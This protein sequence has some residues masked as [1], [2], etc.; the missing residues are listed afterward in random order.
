LERTTKLVVVTWACLAVAAESWLLRGAWAGIVPA[1]IAAFGAA[2]VAT[3]FNR[4]AVGAVLAFTYIFPALI[5]LIR[6]QYHASYGVVWTAALVGAMAPDG[7]RTP[8]H[9]PARWRPALVCSA[10]I[11]IG[12][13]LVA[14]WRE[15][16]FYPGLIFREHAAGPLFM[17]QWILQV[18]LV[19]VVGI[20]WFD[21]L[22]GAASAGPLDMHAT[23]LMPLA[24]SAALMASVAVYQLFVD[25]RW[26]NN[27]VYGEIA[28]ASGTVFDANVC[29]TIAGLW[30]GGVLLWVDGCHRWKPWLMAGGVTL[31]WLAVWATGSRTGFASAVITSGFAVAAFFV[32]RPRAPSRRVIPA[33]LTVTTLGV[34]LL[35]VLTF[36][37]LAAIGPLRRFWTTLPT[38]SGGSV[39][40]F[41]VEN[42]WTR[43]GYGS[44]AVE[45][46]RRFPWFGVGLGSFQTMLPEFV[47]IPPDNAQ[48]W[49]RHQVAELGLIGSLGWAAWL[50]SFGRFVLTRFPSA[51]WT[52]GVARGTLVAF[53]AISFVGMPGQEMSVSITFWTLAFGFVSIVGPPPEGRISTGWWG[54]VAAVVLVFVAGSLRAGQTTLR[55]PLRA[56]RLGTFYQYGFHPI[57]PDGAGGV[58]RWS[59]KRAVA[60]IEA[61]GDWMELTVSVNHVDVEQH[62]VDVRVWVNQKL[63]IDTRLDSIEPIRK[64]VAVPRE[65]PRMFLETWVSRVLKPTDYGAAD[66]RELG[67]LVSWKFLEAGT[68]AAATAL[69]EGVR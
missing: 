9:V 58:Q 14:I 55:P 49:Y 43:N 29:G 37:N 41:L 17:A 32:D 40:G 61:S 36:V 26:L 51:S 39:R 18:A 16:D 8:W 23:V 4:R 44:A 7:I 63:V 31:A 62:P 27:T 24:A 38:L 64:L 65:R 59:R 42:L 46:I 56:Q 66:A 53:A 13:A 35:L 5:F 10:L 52:A 15:M 67:L 47:R 33:I 22:F 30:V 69:R 6:G 25:V 20:L 50:L 28:R 1:T 19:V 2:A 45:M 11:V 48:N 3:A 60:V 34:G 21:W 12:G 68:P 54:L 57:E